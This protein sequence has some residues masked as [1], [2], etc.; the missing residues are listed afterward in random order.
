M[1]AST[2]PN[3]LLQHQKPFLGPKVVTTTFVTIPSFP[4]EAVAIV[5]IA[6]DN[7]AYGDLSE[8]N[9]GLLLAKSE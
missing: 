3:T 6:F 7:D 9:R 1:V 5:C 8:D 2:L 4:I